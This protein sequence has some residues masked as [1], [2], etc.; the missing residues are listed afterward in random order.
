MRGKLLA[1]WGLFVLTFALIQAP[2]VVHAQ[3]LP[4][5]A[6][7]KADA[8]VVLPFLIKGVIQRIEKA[9]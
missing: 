2:S 8:T 6:E 5:Y 4:T 3:E 7:V 9:K 1:M